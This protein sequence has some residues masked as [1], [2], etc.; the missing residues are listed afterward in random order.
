MVGLYGSL[1]FDGC[2]SH[3]GR[4]TAITRWAKITS[5]VGGSLCDVQELAGYSSLAT[6]Q[7]YVEGDTAAN[8]KLV[9][10]CDIKIFV[11]GVIT[12]FGQNNTDDIAWW[13]ALFCNGFNF[14]DI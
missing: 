11:V 7:R 6:T 10:W 9:V 2:S 4:R 13:V 12:S 8:R 3:S 1:G 5:R 14:Y